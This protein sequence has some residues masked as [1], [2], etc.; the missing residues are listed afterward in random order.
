MHRIR[1]LLC[2]ILP[3]LIFTGCS[4]PWNSPYPS[5]DKKANIYYSSFTEQPKT[6]DPARAYSI[7]EA[8]FIAQIYQPPLQ[9]HYLKR[10]YT[11]VPQT[12]AAMPQ[13]V[14]LDAK[15]NVLPENTPEKAIAFTRYDIQIRPGIY[16]QPHPAFA[17]DKTGKYYYHQLK[18][19]D[20]AWTNKLADFPHTGTREL[21]A[22]DYVYEIKRLAHP[23]VQSPIYGV[24]SQYI[25]G[26]HDY[27]NVL[28][29]AYNQLT[30]GKSD[31]DVYLNL[32]AY[33]FPGAQVVDRY[34][35]RILVKGKYPQFLYW[36]A[37]SFF[38]PIPGKPIIFTHNRGWMIEISC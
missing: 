12:A 38:A 15:G 23:K 24:M 30:Q 9:Y 13:A 17:K 20:I 33:N 22:A 28:Q 2:L 37:M 34:R 6:L 16:Y 18:K 27:A 1:I 25:V 36:L 8:V 29:R 19:S 35:Y 21:T 4:N 14:F 11:L 3:L 32:N 10:P 5:A 26:L 31:L 7:N